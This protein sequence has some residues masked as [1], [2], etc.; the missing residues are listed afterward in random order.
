ML[1]RPIIVVHGNPASN[2]LDLYLTQPDA[3]YT[4]ARGGFPLHFPGSTKLY[5]RVPFHPDDPTT[6]LNVTG[7][8]VAPAR[9]RAIS[10]FYIP[11]ENLVERLKRDIGSEDDPAPVFPFAYDWRFDTSTSAPELRDYIGEVLR[12]V[13]LLPQYKA[14]PPQSVDIVA[15]SFGGLVVARYL[16][17]CQVGTPRSTRVQKV[18][19]I[20]TPF[21]GAV[22]A[23]YT[24]IKDLDQREAAR[25][26]PS[27][28]GLLPYFANATVDVTGPGGAPRPIDLISDPTIWNGSSVERSLDSYCARMG[29]SKTGAQRLSELRK[30]AADQRADLASLDVARAL[31]SLDNW[32]PIVGIGRQTNVQAQV[33]SVKQG[34]APDAEFAFIQGNTGDNTGDNTVPFLGAIP[35]FDLAAGAANTPTPPNRLVC[36][37]QD[38][39]GPHEA[40]DWAGIGEELGKVSLHSILPMMDAVQQ[41]LISFLRDTAPR[42]KARAH[43]APGVASNAVNWPAAWGVSV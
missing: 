39:V 35:P 17:S 33:V 1:P 8:A 26:L 21:C 31:G 2:L 37:T 6:T 22:D 3:V 40:S 41:I 7:R 42:F 36:I 43:P 23:V 29:S 11:Y 32:L 27:V 25:T 18:A 9:I 13:S 15:H 34:T 14:A 12:I 38:D 24:M 28:Y 30:S 20:A 19:T 10:A 16:R 5:Q 4:L